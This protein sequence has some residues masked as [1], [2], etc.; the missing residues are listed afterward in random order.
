M[1]TYQHVLPG[2]QAEAARTF[3]ALLVSSTDFH[4]VEDPV[5][6]V[7]DMKWPWPETCSDQGQDGGG[8]RI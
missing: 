2:M 3:E 6:A 8:G 1:A 5:E 7:S 4:Q